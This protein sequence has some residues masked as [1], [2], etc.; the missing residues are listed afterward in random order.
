[1]K[2][3]VVLLIAVALSG[4]SIWGPVGEYNGSFE[5]KGKGLI[6]GS[7]NIAIGAGVGGSQGN[8]FALNVDCGEGFSIT[9]DRA[10]THSDPAK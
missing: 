5:C 8:G 3:L 2:Y 4:C 6:T 9:R 1:M 7:G 10:R